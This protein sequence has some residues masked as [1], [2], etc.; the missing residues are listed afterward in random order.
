MQTMEDS[1]KAYE[2]LD[3]VAL[4]LACAAGVYLVSASCRLSGRVR[5]VISS[6]VLIGIVS[7]GYTKTSTDTNIMRL[8]GIDRNFTPDQVYSSLDKLEN[9]LDEDTLMDIEK[10]L[11][12]KASQYYFKANDFYGDTHR[13]LDT[14]EKLSTYNANKV[15]SICADNAVVLFTSVLLLPS[16]TFRSV[17]LFL[18]LACSLSCLVHF[19]LYNVHES[20]SPIYAHILMFVSHNEALRQFAIY[21][22]SEMT[23]FVYSGISLSVVSYVSMYRVDMHTLRRDVEKLN[24]ETSEEKYREV[25]DTYDIHVSYNKHLPVLY[26]GAVVLYAGAVLYEVYAI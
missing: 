2:A 5:L 7:I 6:I 12:G 13:L 23:L 25:L 24:R 10:K 3:P 14:D 11:T 1:Q 26:V 4:H 19:S 17:R 20:L 22:L 15:F 9:S 21:N 16:Y 8:L 18:L